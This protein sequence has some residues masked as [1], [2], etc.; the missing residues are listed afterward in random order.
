MIPA[1]LRLRWPVGAQGDAIVDH[2]GVIDMPGPRPDIG[3]M[4]THLMLVPVQWVSTLLARLGE[5]VITGDCAWS[6]RI[7]YDGPVLQ[8]GLCHHIIVT[9]GSPQGTW[10]W[11]LF[12][13]TWIDEHGYHPG[14]ILCPAM[15]L[16]VWPD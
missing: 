10:A 13:T 12:T 8:E 9:L 6:A 1:D 4:P 14:G 3:Y 15:Y 2:F 11:R 5:P 7:D 16:G